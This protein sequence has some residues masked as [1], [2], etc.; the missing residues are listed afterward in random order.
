L[1][2]KAG[3][4]AASARPAL[5]ALVYPYTSA[6]AAQ[7]IAC[8]TPPGA[9]RAGKI[10]RDRTRSMRSMRRIVLVDVAP[11]LFVRVQFKPH[12]IENRECAGQAK[13]KDP[14]EIPHR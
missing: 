6:A 10:V 1:A 8:A 3:A 9:A 7:I 11:G 2:V 5:A 12:G 4:V 13:A 14:A